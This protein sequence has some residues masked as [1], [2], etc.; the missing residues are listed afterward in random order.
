MQQTAT[1]SVLETPLAGAHREGGAKMGVW[2]GCALPD[3]FGDW[4][5]EYRFAR[6]GVA[7]IDKNYRAYLSFTGPDRVRYLNAILTNNIKDL[8]TGQGVVSLFLSPQ[9][10]IQ[11]EIETYAE[12]E[13]M[14][15]VSFAMI[16]E[17]LL[18]S[19]DKYIIMD[20]ATLNDETA[21]YGT[22]ALEG[23]KAAP[24][25]QELTG[26]RLADLSELGWKD[27][28]V[29]NS[30]PRDSS[31]SGWRSRRGILGGASATRGAV[32]DPVGNSE[33]SWRRCDRL[34]GAECHAPGAR[35]SVVRVRLRRKTDT[36][37]GGIAEFTH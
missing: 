31:V 9:G 32:E 5:E 4:R 2:F 7:L 25:V 1:G 29:S 26:L 21:N 28:A 27:S 18:P 11:A 16:R 36:A 10:H 15:C 37:R 8:M 23:P 12:E 14:F 33:R 19:L 22:L 3:S 17:K 30:L 24:T 35:R 6:E 34:H 20:D 13:R